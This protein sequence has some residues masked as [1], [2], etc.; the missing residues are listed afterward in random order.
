ML[1][2]AKLFD[3]IEFDTLPEAVQCPWESPSGEIERGTYALV[4]K[5]VLL[6][7]CEAISVNTKA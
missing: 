4:R 7:S 2:T 3:K 5:G 1:I 6:A